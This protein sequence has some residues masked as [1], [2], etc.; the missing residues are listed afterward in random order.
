MPIFEFECPMH[1]KFEV[2]CESKYDTQPCP[3]WMKE[4]SGEEHY[5]QVESEKIEFSI[6]AKRNPEKGIQL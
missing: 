3:S 2:I 4:L 5:C 1:G 6:P